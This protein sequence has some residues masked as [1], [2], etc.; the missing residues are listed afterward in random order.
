M[1]RNHSAAWEL[2]RSQGAPAQIQAPGMGLELFFSVA[3]SII[4][5]FL[6]WKIVKDQP[7][8]WALAAE[9]PISLLPLPLKRRREIFAF[10]QH[11]VL[12]DGEKSYALPYSLAQWEWNLLSALNFIIPLQNPLLLCYAPAK[13]LF[14]AIKKAAEVPI[15]FF[16]ICTELSK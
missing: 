5:G 12:R 6:L 13:I 9:S 4:M 7:G 1:D 15:I 14:I 16:I 11:H 8:K 2:P 3:K 10:P